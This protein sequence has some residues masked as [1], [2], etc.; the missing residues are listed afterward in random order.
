MCLNT[1]QIDMVTAE[2]TSVWFWF[3]LGILLIA[4]ML[5]GIQSELK[6]ELIELI[7]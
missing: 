3:N 4:Y 5:I 6:Y 1:S 7:D 2:D